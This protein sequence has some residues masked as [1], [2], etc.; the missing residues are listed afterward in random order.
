MA[1]RGVRRPRKQTVRCCYGTTGTSGYRVA[2]STCYQQYIIIRIR[3]EWALGEDSFPSPLRAYLSVRTAMIRRLG[4]GGHSPSEREVSMNYVARRGRSAGRGLLEKAFKGLPL[5]LTVMTVRQEFLHLIENN[6]SSSCSSEGKFQ[7]IKLP[8][9]RS[10][11]SFY[12]LARLQNNSVT[13][14]LNPAV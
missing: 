4:L 14:A 2:S 13:Y 7:T 11:T 8:L 3:E 9:Q 1:R 10:I 12:S 5:R 6:W